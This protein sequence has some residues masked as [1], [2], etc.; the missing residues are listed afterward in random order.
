MTGYQEIPTDPSYNGQIVTMTYP[1]IGTDGVNEQDEV[2][3]QAGKL[4]MRTR[5]Y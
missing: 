1:R 4:A 2:C 3:S 5:A